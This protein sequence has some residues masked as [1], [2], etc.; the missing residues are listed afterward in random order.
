MSRAFSFRSTIDIFG[1]FPSFGVGAISIFCGFSG[2]ET[3]AV[4]PIGTA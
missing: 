4:T 1:A 3:Y 2:G